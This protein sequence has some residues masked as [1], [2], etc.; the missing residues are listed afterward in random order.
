MKRFLWVALQLDQ[1][2]SELSDHS[3]QLAI[4]SIPR[5][6]SEMYARILSSSTARDTSRS[7][8]RLFK[9]LAAAF[10]PLT[11]D[12]I[13]EMAS[14]TIGD[15]TWDP[16]KCI[17]DI[18]KLIG[19][20]GSLLMIE[21]EEQTV[22]FVHHSAKHFCQGV[23]EGFGHWKFCFSDAE[24]HREIGETAVTYLSYGIFDTRLSTKVIPKV[25]VAGITDHI[26]QNTLEKSHPVARLAFSFIKPSGS[27]KRDIGQF[28]AETQKETTAGKFEKVDHP[29]L[30]YAKNF[31][32][33]HTKGIK[34]S[35]VHELWKRLFNEVNL[36]DL[37]L[38]PH[39]L[40]PLD[41]FEM[42]C[43]YPLAPAFLWAVNYSA[44][45]VFDRAMGI[46]SE[47]SFSTD[48][49]WMRFRFFR[50]LLQHL[51]PQDLSAKVPY[52][53]PRM[54]Q[55]LLPMAI[56]LRVYPAVEWM[57]PRVDATEILRVFEVA[58]SCGNYKSAAFI[59]TNTAFRRSWPYHK[60]TLPNNLFAA[61]ASSNNAQMVSMLLRMTAGKEAGGDVSVFS[62]VLF[63]GMHHVPLLRSL[64]NCASTFLWPHSFSVKDIICTLQ[65]L[66]ISPEINREVALKVFI[67]I[68]QANCG[69][70]GIHDLTFRLACSIGSYEFAKAVCLDYCDVC[71]DPNVK[72]HGY[73]FKG[74]EMA[75]V[76]QTVSGSRVRLANW[77]VK[78]GAHRKDPRIYRRAI[79]LKS[80]QLANALLADALLTGGERLKDALVFCAHHELLHFSVLAA[81]LNGI[82][83][84]LKI[85]MDFKNPSTGPT[86]RHSTVTQALMIQESDYFSHQ[87]IAELCKRNA[88]MRSCTSPGAGLL[89]TSMEHLISPENPSTWDP[90]IQKTAKSQLKSDICP[91][92]YSWLICLLAASMR[93]V[94]RIQFIQ[95]DGNTAVGLD[96]LKN[97]LQLLGQMRLSSKF[98]PAVCDRQEG[99]LAIREVFGITAA[100]NEEIIASSSMSRSSTWS[101]WHAQTELWRFVDLFVSWNPTK[102]L[103][104]ESALRELSFLIGKRSVEGV[105]IA[106]RSKALSVMEV[107]DILRLADTSQDLPWILQCLLL[108]SQKVSIEAFCDFSRSWKRIDMVLSIPDESQQAFK[109]MGWTEE[110]VSMLTDARFNIP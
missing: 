68:L 36:H 105:F 102:E 73:P 14:V 87:S 99:L 29:F 9:L 2:C 35:A 47:Y 26:I 15:A 11:I 20:C 89:K 64:F 19:F 60:I 31:W 37:E 56:V 10:V 5:D 39:I 6:L 41:D 76:L 110:D 71:P 7:H 12:Q 85:G 38:T 27:V 58:V 48:I 79:V 8:I 23:L 16:S 21:E 33:L 98:T 90:Q 44:V 18:L 107:Y 96:H 70:P 72:R 75:L 104:R 32:M 22:R 52:L 51:H 66:A 17:N 42:P 57:L 34:N 55:R 1:I 46:S 30:S 40:G 101:R 106:C 13:Q 49:P 82:D 77:L 80:W 3:I 4:K 83:F 94:V 59:S 86:F 95:V 69:I 28:L 84:L 97:W 81:D 24:A 103:S 88:F 92:D 43:K 63:S 108:L 45:A 53:E 61:A 62:G 78:K 54:M 50:S 93:K 109:L 25:E 65:L 91:N 67:I 100:M 74:D